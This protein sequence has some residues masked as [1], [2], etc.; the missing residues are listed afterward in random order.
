MWY[1]IQI[2][3]LDVKRSS[4]PDVFCKKG[5]FRNFAK[6]TGKHLCQRQLFLCVSCKTTHKPPKNQPNHAQTSQTTHKSVKP[7]TNYPQA[8]QI[9]LKPAKQQTNHLLISQKSHR[10]FPEDIFYE[11][12]HFLA[13]STR[14][15][16]Q[17]H[18]FS[19]S[20]WISH[21]AF[22]IAQFFTI[23]NCRLQSQS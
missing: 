16:K 20:C 18:F 21:F 11:R 14:K 2:S 17:M 6:F 23:P 12:Q 8:S 9:T 22:S 3:Q 15:E 1:L 10:Y 19:C 13:H 7:P 4:R 5:V